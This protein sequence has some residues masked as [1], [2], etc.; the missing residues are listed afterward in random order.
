[1][2]LKDVFV[3]LWEILRSRQSVLALPLCFL[4]MGAGAAMGL[5]S[6]VARDWGAGAGMV[7]LMNGWLS[8]VI[9][10]AGCLVGGRL[11]DAMDRKAAYAVAGAIL[12]VVALI[13]G[14][15]APSPTSYAVLC[16]A[17][18]LA[19]GICYGTF[20]GFVLELI[21]GGAASTKYNL[22][23]SLSNIPIWYMTRIDGWAAQS[24][25]G[26][27][28]LRVDALAGGIGVAGLIIAFLLLR[29]FRPRPSISSP[30]VS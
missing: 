2:K 10:I 20:T 21:G 4:P 23:A 6:A 24:F 11:S 16:I 19:T 27:R 22:F 28:M 8:G 25:G 12:A 26:P 9:M 13:M 14:L 3:E 29:A 1:L 30:H 15:V 5:F 18:A 7:E 17:Y